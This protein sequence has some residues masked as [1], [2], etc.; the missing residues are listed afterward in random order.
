MN[1][2]V[3]PFRFSLLLSLTL[4][5][6]SHRSPADLPPDD[7][8]C[9]S[10]CLANVQAANAARADAML[11]PHHFDGEHLNSL[12]RAKLDALLASDRQADPLTVYLNLPDS[13]KDSGNE[14]RRAAVSRYLH[15]RGLSDS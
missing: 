11:Y 9:A 6:C 5:G 1:T 2:L 13:E 14:G 15:D 4:I 8:P 12:G 3:T 10:H 7:A